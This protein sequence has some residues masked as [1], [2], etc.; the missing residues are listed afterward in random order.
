LQL[1]T[2]QPLGFAVQYTATTFAALG[3]AFYT[4]WNL[5]LVTLATVP[6]SALI[7]SFLASKMQPSIEAQQSE[8]NRASKLANNAISLIDIVKCFN[9][10]AF[11]KSQYYSA[12]KRAARCYLRQA[13]SNALQIGFVRVM[14]LGM[15]VQGFWYGSS[16]VNS[17]QQSAGD[18]LTTFWACL[19]ATQSI[20]Q[21][22]PQMIVLE[23]GRA[24]GASLRVLL[25]RVDKGKKANKMM[26]RT[27]PTFCEGDIEVR[28]VS[29]NQCFHEPT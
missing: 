15:F 7:L 5:T 14:T 20:E 6:V 16:I 27:T 24:A 26:G 17:G 23:K 9:G 3:L 22:L 13:R 12:V 28:K 11:E 18:V 21:I 29:N 8:L 25:L 4:S 2:S 19:I 1:A 10:Q